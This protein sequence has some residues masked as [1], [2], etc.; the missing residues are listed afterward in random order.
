MSYVCLWTPS[1][2]TGEAPLAE[3]AALLLEEAPRVAAE[4]RGVLWADARGLPAPRLAR[5]LL[6]R[7]AA[8]GTEEVRAGVAEVPVAAELAARSASVPVTVVE[9]GEERPFLAP[10]PLELLDPDP[11]LLALLEGV[12]IRTCG[13]LAERERE[14]VEVRFGAAGSALW[15]LARA[16]DPRRLFRPFPRERPHGSLDFIDY[17]VEDA[18]RLIFPLNGLLERVCGTLRAR[19]ERTR[20]MTL[21]LRLRGGSG[22]ERSLRLAIP[23]ARRAPWLRR[24]RRVLDDF[25]LSAPVTGVALR[26]EGTEPASARQGDLFDRGFPTA[27]RVE[28]AMARLLDAHGPLF[29]EPETCRHP[30]A[31]R[32]TRWRERDPAGRTEGRP[33][34]ALPPALPASGRPGAARP[35]PRARLTLHLPPR[36]R[37]IRVR[38]RRRRDH[39]L[40]VQYLEDRAWRDLPVCAGP[41]RISGGHW[42]ERPFAREYFQC[43]TDDGRLVRL[44]RD[45][46]ENAWYLHG[47]W[48]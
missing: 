43:L 25:T 9:P 26:V 19:G 21:R 35:K 4:A 39:L 44:F 33:P 28:E 30:L 13:R 34:S 23:T 17:A 16:D 41:R 5:T 6:E 7:L 10:L 12:G 29:V 2:A 32:R 24:I 22:S 38:Y 40:P 31:E 42:E 8:C 20:H 3:R 18:A 14:A 36:P 27:G 11:R 47:W 46:R 15:R 1:R 37:P 45:A 48:E